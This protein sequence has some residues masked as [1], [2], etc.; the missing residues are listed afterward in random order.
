MRFL[1]DLSID[2]DFQSIIVCEGEFNRFRVVNG[3]WL[4]S[5]DS[6]TGKVYYLDEN[7]KVL[8]FYLGKL[9]TN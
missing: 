2:P 6:E 4:G 3:N 8:T 9:I 5:Y 7:G 1:I